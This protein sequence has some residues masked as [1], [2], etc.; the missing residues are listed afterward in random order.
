MSLLATNL[1]NVELTLPKKNR[2]IMRKQHKK[3]RV[4]NGNIGVVIHALLLLYL[5]D[6][7]C[8]FFGVYLTRRGRS[9][10]I[11]R[12]KGGVISVEVIHV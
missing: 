5:S 6:A 10:R 11:K 2:K 4:N 8:F 7:I 9:L 12:I 3:K 1:Q